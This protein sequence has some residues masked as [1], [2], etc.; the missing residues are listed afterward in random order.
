VLAQYALAATS[1]SCYD[2]RI[3]HNRRKE[4]N[5]DWHTCMVNKH[6]IVVYLKKQQ[7][8]TK[9]DNNNDHRTNHP[10]TASPTHWALEQTSK[11]YWV[12][13]Q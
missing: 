11:S 12:L 7:Q 4:S 6:N 9:D 13:F 1:S 3:W 10:R 5:L 2:N 8:Q